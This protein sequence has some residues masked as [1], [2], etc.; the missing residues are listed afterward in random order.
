MNDSRNWGKD[1]SALG[2][3]SQAEEVL[4]KLKEKR[5]GKKFKLIQIDSK[6]WKE[7]EVKD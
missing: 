5:K 6:T 7:V 4:N 1:D 2:K 3:R